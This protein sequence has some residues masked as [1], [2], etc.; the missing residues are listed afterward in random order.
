M[1]EIHKNKLYIRV[2]DLSLV[3]DLHK[4]KLYNYDK[5][6]RI[7]YI[8]G[9]QIYLLYWIYTRRNY[10]IMIKSIRI[11][12][13]VMLEIHKNKLYIRVPDLSL[14]LDLH[15]NK[16]YNYDKSTRI[17]YIFGSQILVLNLHKKKLYN[18]DKIHKNKLYSHVGNTQ[19]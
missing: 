15:K 5:S 7:N 17:N 8:F 4:N 18:Y 10:T 14:A 16:L 9:S 2:P 1:L 11:N 19:E 13:I 3:L 12:Y 6:T